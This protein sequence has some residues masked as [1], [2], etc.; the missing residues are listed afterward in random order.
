M[1]RLCPILEEMRLWDIYSV[2]TS[3]LHFKLE[4]ATRTSD[5]KYPNL[6]SSYTTPSKRLP[7]VPP[8]APKNLGVFL[9]AVPPPHSS[10]PVMI[11][12]CKLDSSLSRFLH[13][14]GHCPSTSSCCFTLSLCHNLHFPRSG[15][16]LICSLLLSQSD[17]SKAHCRFSDS[18][19][20]QLSVAP[21]DCE[22]E[23]RFFSLR[24]KGPHGLASCI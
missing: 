14:H 16:A 17:L 19:A 22:L 9:D 15:L 20:P 7:C 5:S 11:Q 4:W 8:P 21:Q 12:P 24:F 2:L 23:P 3:L 10:T 18:L 1:L 6:D 13:L